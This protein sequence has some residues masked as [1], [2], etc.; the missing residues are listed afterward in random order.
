VTSL[1]AILLLSLVHGSSDSIFER[2]ENDPPPVQRP[3][4]LEPEEPAQ[5]QPETDVASPA[6]P[7]TR[8]EPDAEE[9]GPE[10]DLYVPATDAAAQTDDAAPAVDTAGPEPRS[11]ARAERRR[12]RAASAKF[13]RRGFLIALSLAIT[14][15]SQNDER[16][17]TAA[18]T[19]CDENV[20]GPL[21]RIELGYRVAR[22]V[23][24]FVSAS[25]S[26]NGKEVPG[27]TSGLDAKS[28]WRVFDVG[29]G[30]LLFPVTKGRFDPYAGAM[31]GYTRQNELIEIG[32]ERTKQILK[33]GLVR[34]T[35]GWNIYFVRR[36]AVGPRFDIDLPFAGVACIESNVPHL[37]EEIP[38]E[39]ETIREIPDRA[40][41]ESK[42]EKRSFRRAFA[43]PWSV[44]VNVS[45]FF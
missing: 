33:R 38:G 20:I 3:E 8:A 6:A 4:A 41:L 44:G 45:A 19:N 1:A 37:D 32:D 42:L 21:G 22:Y 40:G 29:G 2:A 17:H 23:A 26:Y 24:P 25:Y 30:L 16:S 27:T 43:R 39:C 18:S 28:S 12:R 36:F 9:T 14:N 34:L 15:C 10:T 5:E 13:S 11:S 31:L 7:E 35:T